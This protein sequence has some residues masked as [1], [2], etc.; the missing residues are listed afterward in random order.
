MSKRLLQSGQ[1]LE[2]MSS[3]QKTVPTLNLRRVRQNQ[4]RNEAFDLLLGTREAVRCDVGP[5]VPSVGLQKSVLGC[6]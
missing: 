1:G 6:S 3:I 2:K 5:P 4:S